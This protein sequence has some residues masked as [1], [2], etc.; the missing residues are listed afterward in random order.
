VTVRSA[1][2][3]CRFPTCSVECSAA[4]RGERAPHVR[5]RR[6]HS[7]VGLNPG[8]PR[9]PGEIFPA[10]SRQQGDHGE[11]CTPHRSPGATLPPR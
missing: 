5:R 9:S 4:A 1:S 10:A 8:S 11:L 6:P 2:R 7:S 3:R